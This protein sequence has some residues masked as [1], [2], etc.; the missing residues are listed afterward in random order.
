MLFRSVASIFAGI[1]GYLDP[2]P[3]PKVKAFE[4]GF[5]AHLRTQR[6]EILKDIREK[7][8]LTDETKAKLTAAVE[9][10]SKQFS[11]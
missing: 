7:K 11:S 4:T 10:F 1:N 9:E 3:V 6:P 8:D 5:L 2:L